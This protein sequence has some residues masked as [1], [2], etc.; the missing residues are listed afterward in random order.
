MLL[1]V[2]GGAGTIEPQYVPLKLAGV[3]QAVRV[4]Y[5]ALA[6]GR[7]AVDAVEAA[8]RHMENDPI[9]NCGYG[10]ALTSAGTVECDAFIMDGRTL[11]SGAVA[12]VQR[13]RHPISLARA[14][15][16]RTDHCLMMG[17]GAESLAQE[18]GIDLVDNESLVHEIAQ[19]RLNAYKILKQKAAEGMPSGGTAPTNTTNT[20][21]KALGAGRGEHDT[22][23]AVAVDWE[24]NCAAATST[25]ELTGKRVGRVGDSPIIGAGG[26]A[27]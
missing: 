17:T 1:L 25:G 19:K 8:V 3:K 6:N 24:G 12:G 21:A 27:D 18:V 15:M 13:I 10:S 7:S 11:K 14:V 2:H 20:I 5:E 16:D 22:V 9:M 4:G 26:Y 23:G